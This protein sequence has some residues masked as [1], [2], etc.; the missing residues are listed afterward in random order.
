MELLASFAK[1]K[2]AKQ[3]TLGQTDSRSC[4]VSFPTQ[5]SSVGDGSDMWDVCVSLHK[6]GWGPAPV[7]EQLD[8]MQDCKIIPFISVCFGRHGA[9]MHERCGLMAVL[10]RD[11]LQ[12][13][14]MNFHRTGFQELGHTVITLTSG[15]RLSCLATLGGLHPGPR[16]CALRRGED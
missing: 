10:L 15:S 9:A 13:F 16:P 4:A 5:Q 3:L 6:F 14:P 8:H 2:V 11:L 12:R 1:V 7:R